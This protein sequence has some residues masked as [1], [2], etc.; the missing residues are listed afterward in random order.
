M[1][2]KNLL[3]KMTPDNWVK[4]QNEY[5]SGYELYASAGDLLKIL[6]PEV[7]SG[8]VDHTETDVKE[9]PGYGSVAYTHI[10][11]EEEFK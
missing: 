6:R 3:K 10:F 9:L 11:W 2:V 5:R 1:R 8:K 7:L 4:I